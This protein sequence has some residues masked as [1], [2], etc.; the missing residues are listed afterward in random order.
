MADVWKDLR[1]GQQV[2]RERATLAG[3][4]LHRENGLNRNAR[5]SLDKNHSRAVITSRFII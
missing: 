4:L 3:M 1:L 5:V 2:L